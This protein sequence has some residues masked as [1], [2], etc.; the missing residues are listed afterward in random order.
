M[1]ILTRDLAFVVL[2]AALFSAS[3][4][5]LL[6]AESPGSSLSVET[7]RTR[8]RND[9]AFLAS[10]QL[11]GRSVT[12]DTIDVAANYVADRMKSIGL[13]TDL[14]DGSPMQSVEIPL[15]ARAGSV[16]ENH[17]TFFPPGDSLQS[18]ADGSTKQSNSENSRPED[19]D[20]NQSL[21]G[22][23]SATLGSG[24]NPLAIGISEGDFDGLVSFV[25]YGITAPKLGYDDYANQDV[26]GRA[27]MMLRK[28]PTSE[29][30]DAVFNG[31][32]NTRHA[33]FATKIS[34]ALAH[35]AAAVIL[36][37]D[38]ASA[39]ASVDEKQKRLQQERDRKENLQK[40]IESLPEN[41]VNSRESMTKQLAGVESM[42]GAAEN[43]LNVAETGLI[44][45]AEAGNGTEK[46]KRI[47]VLSIS[48]DLASRI[49][50]Q[51]TG[52]Q[53][54]AIERQINQSV[55]PRSMPLD[56]WRVSLSVQLEPTAAQT[57]NVIGVLP[58]RGSLADE[59]VVIGAH[60]DHVGMGGFASLAPGTVAVHNG[61]DD[62]ASGVAVL[63]ATADQL[64]RRLGESEDQRRVIFIAFTG[65][66]RGLVGSKHYAESPRFPLDSTVAMIN[67][68]MVGR[69]RDNE[70]T[71]YGTG[72]GVGMDALVDRVNVRHRFNLYKV[73]S[74]YGPSDHQS[75]YE[76]GVPVLFFFTGLH[77]DYHRPTDDFDKI[78]FGGMAR[79]TDMVSDVA[80]EFATGREVPV[81]AKTNNKVRIRRQLTAYLGVSLAGIRNT[82]RVSALTAGAPGQAA[83][84]RVGDTI[85]KMGGTYIHTTSEV[86]ETLRQ[87]SPG[88]T[89]T[90]QLIRN[91]ARIVRSVKLGS[92]PNEREAIESE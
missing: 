23:L 69:L 89:I 17:V 27:V 73:E 50:K 77:N 61:A 29:S 12:D 3:A 56:G 39:L 55:R 34:N 53:L 82:V 11:R 8:Q 44:A 42:I 81:Y 19:G 41:A 66:E 18:P 68:D 21:A 22:K 33:F 48:R 20:R 40:Q 62:N 76:R 54:Q 64:K 65:E 25:G 28:E 31:G 59:S 10:E 46:D 26:A 24:M 52:R 16:G 32:K 36:I 71:L 88:D 57:A 1:L 5:T 4:P 30:G 80:A 43:E 47:P 90:I 75:F 70:L 72:S 85:E 15:G 92:R 13:R 67:L 51:S 38:Q 83:G 7:S 58:G 2:L 9:V 79:I 74:G 78:D 6:L 86:L 14:F 63:L 49:L 84:L 60:Y 45:V 35:D 87:H 91:G 37:N